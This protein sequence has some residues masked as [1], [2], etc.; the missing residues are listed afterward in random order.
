LEPRDYFL[1]DRYY[2]KCL[3]T[4]QEEPRGSSFEEIWLMG[5]PFLRKYYSIYDMDAK[6]IGL[7]GVAES[8]R[9]DFKDIIEVN[10]VEEVDDFI[11]DSVEGFL[12]QINGDDSDN[13][14]L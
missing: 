10:T 7:V 6:K 11:E 2:K 13:L 1:Y 9:M 8:T 14:I 5:D 12:K 3:L 4:I